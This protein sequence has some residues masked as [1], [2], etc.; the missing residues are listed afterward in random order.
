MH[1]LILG[2][3]GMLGR[4]LAER[5]ARDGGAA[6]AAVERLT[7]ADVVAP[8][9]PPGL[10]G[11]TTCLAVDLVPDTQRHWFASPRSAVGFL[12]HAAA[13]DLRRLGSRI[14]LN[15]PGVSATV[16]EQIEALRLVGGEAA[17][18]LIR[19]EPDPAVE[20][21]TGGWARSFAPRR[22]E[23]LGFTAETAFVDIVRAHVAAELGGSLG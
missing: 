20:R 12:V 19:R 2:A 13:L 21:I 6:G 14:N 15:M 22:A 10:P 17:V 8:A 4:K 16:A 18:A 7:L 1:V 3:A 23:A 9:A 5:L 11:A